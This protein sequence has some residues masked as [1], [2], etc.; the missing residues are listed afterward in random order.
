MIKSTQ[1]QGDREI[2]VALDI[3][4][5]NPEQT[6]LNKKILKFSTQLALAE[7]SDLHIVHAWEMYYENFLRDAFSSYSDDEVEQ[8]AIKEKEM[9]TQLLKELVNEIPE[10]QKSDYINPKIHLLQGDPIK[11]IPKVAQ[12]VEV[13]LVVIASNART[14]IPGL[15]IGNTAETVLQQLQCSVLVIKPDG[16]IS[17]IA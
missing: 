10:L 3:K 11:I 17:P 16:F 4:P 5:D 7:F 2:L 1:Q 12:T 14:G 13:E 8:L 6:E 9:H 15:I